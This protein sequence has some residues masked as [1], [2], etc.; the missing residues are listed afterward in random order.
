MDCLSAWLRSRDKLITLSYLHNNIWSHAPSYYD[1]LPTEPLNVRPRHGLGIKLKSSS[2][3]HNIIVCQIETYVR[4]ETKFW[5]SCLLL[6]RCSPYLC[7]NWLILVKWSN[8]SGHQELPGGGSNKV[9]ISLFIV[10][11]RGCR[12][13]SLWN[14]CSHAWSKTPGQRTW[15]CTPSDREVVVLVP[16]TRTDRNRTEDLG[17]SGLIK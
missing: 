4:R 3:C 6:D 5:W 2:T 17:R 14:S 10:C 8:Y 12:S 7:S 13:F 9:I 16:S 11:V 1:R 15:T